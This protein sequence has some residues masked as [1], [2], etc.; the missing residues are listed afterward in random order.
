MLTGTETLSLVLYSVFCLL[1]LGG[2]CKSV[3][4]KINAITVVRGDGKLGPEMRRAAYLFGFL[5]L[6]TV[7]CIGFVVLLNRFEAT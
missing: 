4:Q 2:V 6:V 1:G 3:S 7:L 5:G